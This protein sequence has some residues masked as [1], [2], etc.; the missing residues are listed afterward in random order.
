VCPQT[1]NEC[2]RL[3]DGSIAHLWSGY[4]YV[5]R[6]FG[7]PHV[8]TATECTHQVKDDGV[9]ACVLTGRVVS[10]IL[11]DVHA[12]GNFFEG[13]HEMTTV[14]PI[15]P[16]IDSIRRRFEALEAQRPDAIAIS[17]RDAAAPARAAA[18]TAHG[19]VCV[20]G[21]SASSRVLAIDGAQTAYQLPAPPLGARPDFPLL[22]PRPTRAKKPPRLA[23]PLITTRA[24]VEALRARET[25]SIAGSYALNRPTDYMIREHFASLTKVLW[26]QL[27]AAYSV[28]ARVR[29]LIEAEHAVV[30]HFTS[31][32]GAKKQAVEEQQIPFVAVFAQH[33]TATARARLGEE[34]VHILAAWEPWTSG[35]IRRTV[36]PQMVERMWKMWC[37]LTRT[38]VFQT[39][40][41]PHKFRKIGQALMN[42]V[43]HGFE[44]RA[45]STG[46]A[47][48]T[49]C[50]H[51][52]G[53]ETKCSH[54]PAIITIAAPTRVVQQLLAPPG[55]NDRVHQ[56]AFGF[57][58]KRNNYIN[59]LITSQLDV[60]LRMA[61]L[62]V[63]H[64]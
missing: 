51:I 22:A 29:E 39:K 13:G 28:R 44:I 30:A 32:R 18:I 9:M 6:E 15:L 63:F 19:M 33:T 53:V 47:V 46:T 17:A 59:Q 24:E 25:H 23:D 45:C 20:L 60:G 26:D 35:T 21:A 2:D 27:E 54:Q 48:Y 56:A 3:A 11:A 41:Q 5:C 42:I 55:I 10:S 12:T 57:L 49:T 61:D 40:R 37:L 62:L 16:D 1:H 8:C 7:T 64:V 50:S 52:T 38:P 34:Y 4:V 31:R 58:L 36:E 43:V 14:T